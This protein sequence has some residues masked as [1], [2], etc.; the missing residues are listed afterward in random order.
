MKTRSLTLA[1]CSVFAS[2]ALAQSAAQPATKASG[3]AAPAQSQP[4]KS[5]AIPALHDFKPKQPQRIELANGVVIYLQ[6]DHELP[7]IDGTVLIRGG[8]R[9]VPA[10]KT[11]LSSLYGQT[12]RT[13][14]STSKSGD[15][16]DAE[17]AEKAASIETGGGSATS[18]L[19]W[20][21]FR[22]DFDSVFGEAVDLLLHPAFKQDK[23][24]LAQRGLMTSISRR[25]DEP[26]SIAGREASKLVYGANSPY[27]R[28]A[29]YSTVLSVTLD[30]LKAWH[31]RTVIANGIIVAIE[32][33]FDSAAM[34]A[35]LR[36]AFGPLQRGTPI[37]TP[38]ADFPGPT[39]GVYFADKE[40]INQ[41]TVE[42]VGLGT[43][44]SNPDYYALSVMNEIFSG[45]FGSRVFQYVRTKLGLA[46][47]VGGNFSAAYDHPGV[48]LSQVG[49]KSVSTVPATQAVLDVIA[50]LKTQ[51]PTPDE[52]RKAKDQVLNSFIFN[53]DTPEKTLNEQVTLAFYGY[54][55]DFL[56]K[57]HDGIEKVTAED[58][59][60]VANKY[61]D[62]SK[63]AILV[64]GN[65]S[66]IQPPLA[67]LGKVTELDISIPPPPG[68]TAAAGQ[69][70]APAQ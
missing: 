40:D 2:A 60:R 57:F 55:S 62:V 18:T 42:I 56:E 15:A 33:D 30:D 65:K 41:S 36:A 3:S 29:E 8:S 7:F 10:A 47:D 26:D 52:M 21:S 49:T 6:E 69:G 11:G 51:P 1:I 70:N 58:V 19:E 38:K 68:K 50:K 54:P 23:L 61:I 27:A 66:E 43:Q 16:L 44:R 13:S 39:P 45:G 63:L 37:E 14:G 59:T 32:G 5:I 9:D 64:V 67:Q 46:Y 28:Q 4:W 25:N 53:F 34:E 17:L 24:Q 31:D 48:F 22:Q 12:W 20:S 35:K